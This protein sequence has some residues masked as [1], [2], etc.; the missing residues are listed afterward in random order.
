MT[1][2]RLAVDVD[3]QTHGCVLFAESYQSFPP[4]TLRERLSPMRLGDVRTGELAER[5]PL[6]PAAVRAAGL[7]YD[8]Q[9][10]GSSYRRCADCRYLGRCSVCPMSI[11]Y[12]NGGSDPTAIPDFLCAYN[13][14]ALAYR[15][16]FPRTRPRRARN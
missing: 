5:L 11:G 8:K 7:F 15:D 6:Y 16:R 2:E 1:G 14:V 3:G 12:A 13:L 10:K 9:E 4:P